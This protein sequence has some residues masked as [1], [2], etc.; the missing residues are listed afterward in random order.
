MKMPSSPSPQQINAL[1]SL[2]NRGEL[3]VAIN[4]ANELVRQFPSAIILYNILGAAH[5]KKGRKEDAL[6]CFA[7]AVEIDPRFPDAHNNL[8]ATLR[9]LGRPEEAIDSYKDALNL[10]PGYAEAHYNLGNALNDL[11]RQEEAAASFSKALE[12]KPDYFNAHNNLGLALNNLGRHEEALASFS[13]AAALAPN[14][15]SAFNNLGVTFRALG[16]QEQAIEQYEKALKIKPDYDEAHYNLANAFSDLGDQ[17]RAL[18]RY[19]AALQLNPNLAEAYRSMGSIKTYEAGDPQIDKMQKLLAAPGATEN[20]KMHLSF[21]LGMAKD[22]LKEFEKAFEYFNGGNALRKKAFGFEISEEKKLFDTIIETFENGPS[23]TEIDEK[24]IDGSR[25]TP[26][27]I[28]G[29]MRS[30]TSLIEQILASH[31]DVYGAG[32]LLTLGQSV[33]SIN[34]SGTSLDWRQLVEIK[35]SYMRYLS[36]LGASEPFITDKAPLN[37]RWIGFIRHALPNARIIH[38]KRD[39]VATCWSIYKHFFSSIGNGYAYD[40]RDVAEYY[41]LYLRLMTYWNKKFPV[42]IYEI[43]YEKLT[44]DQESETRKLLAHMGLGWEPQT[45]DFHK[46]KRAVATVSAAQV[47]KKLYRGSSEEWK[48]YEQFIQPMIKILRQEN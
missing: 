1:V 23:P 38:V 20:D 4:Q 14:N 47:R 40:L 12:L 19:A 48:N 6:A 18:A 41:R 15:P 3:E 45:L 32:E 21:A 42:A 9:N 24:S 44:E 7:K 39:P 26:V 11:G 28:V 16:R 8:G 25:P 37:F 29:M 2:Y 33:Q 10:K 43:S 46:T 17:E 34:W 5:S 35:Q 27:F 31:S 30:G 13:K 36:T 22:D